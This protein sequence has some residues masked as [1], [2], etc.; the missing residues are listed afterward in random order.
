MEPDIKFLDFTNLNDSISSTIFESKIFMFH[1]F[2]F[3]IILFSDDFITLS[4]HAESHGRDFTDRRGQS[5][6][7]RGR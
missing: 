4:C 1:L 7:G 3:G 5:E 2:Y 6:E